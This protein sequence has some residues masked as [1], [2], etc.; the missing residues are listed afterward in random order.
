MCLRTIILTIMGMLIAFPAT[1]QGWIEFVD[2]Q[3]FYGINMPHDPNVE[4]STYH[5][6]FG[7]DYP[8]KVY[9]TSDGLVEYKVTVVDYTN[10]SELEGSRG[11]WDYAGSV[12]YAAWQIRKRGGDITHDGWTEAD[13]IPGHHL[14]ITNADNSRTYAAIHSHAMRLYIFEAFAA[15]GAIAPIQYQQSVIFLDEDGEIVRF[16]TDFRTRI[17]PGR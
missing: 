14:Q 13:R 15:P 10:S 7:A 5:S 17:D 3:E 8:G 16:D 2:E 11:V 4:N 12:A 1:A 9:T 6:E